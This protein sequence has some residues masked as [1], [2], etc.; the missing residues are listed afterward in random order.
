MEVEEEFCD[1]AGR[2]PL[3]A[4]M[5]H[6]ALLRDLDGRRATLTCWQRARMRE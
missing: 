5:H 1:A 2:V 3:W 4:R 6:V